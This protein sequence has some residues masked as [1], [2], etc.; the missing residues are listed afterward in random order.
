MWHFKKNS[1]KSER[2]A[3]LFAVQLYWLI[4]GIIFPAARMCPYSFPIP[5]CVK[6]VPGFFFFPQQKQNSA[7]KNC[8]KSGP[9]DLKWSKELLR[10]LSLEFIFFSEGFGIVQRSEPQDLSSEI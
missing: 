8:S 3:L 1:N 4:L 10:S 5:L 7:E 6:V 9:L 2:T